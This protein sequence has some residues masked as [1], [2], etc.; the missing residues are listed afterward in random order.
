MDFKHQTFDVKSFDSKTI[1]S[2][3]SKGSLPFYCIFK[4]GYFYVKHIPKQSISMKVIVY[5]VSG[6]NMQGI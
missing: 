5:G 6:I 2:N 1:C 3:F 4:S